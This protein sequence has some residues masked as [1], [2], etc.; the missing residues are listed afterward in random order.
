[1]L[2]IH[3]L[4][5]TI[6]SEENKKVEN[7]YLIFVIQC[8]QLAIIQNSAIL[9]IYYFVYIISVSVSVFQ[10]SFVMLPNEL[11]EKI[12]Y[13][14]HLASFVIQENVCNVILLKPSH[15]VRVQRI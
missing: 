8:V 6:V 5:L 1:M 9:C 3:I 12:R 2:F 15:Q 14:K 7:E 13:V 11:Y 10:Q 4:R